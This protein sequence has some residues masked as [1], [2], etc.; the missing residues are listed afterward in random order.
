MES[1][2]GLGRN[3]YNSIYKNYIN[4]LVNILV[5]KLVGKLVGKLVD[6]VTTNL[7]LTQRI[8]LNILWTILIN[9]VR[10]QNSWTWSRPILILS[11]RLNL[12]SRGLGRDQYN[13]ISEK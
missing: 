12:I 5:N 3:K 8:E 1:S 4:K 6:L 2:R 9:L 13:S 11:W 7:I 10:G